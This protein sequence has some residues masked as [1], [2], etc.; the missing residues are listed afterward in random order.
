M[1]FLNLFRSSPEMGKKPPRSKSLECF[2]Y[3]AKVSEG[4]RFAR[5]WVILCYW[6][7]LVQLC[8]IIS[9]DVVDI[10]GSSLY[11]TINSIKELKCLICDMVASCSMGFRVLCPEKR[12]NNYTL[13]YGRDHQLTCAALIM[14]RRIWAESLRPSFALIVCL[15]TLASWEQVTSAYSRLEILSPVARDT[16]GPSEKS[17]IFMSVDRL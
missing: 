11:S 3:W 16:L 12:N 15:L 8:D 13:K 5:K 17:K 4:E 2:M 7:S 10:N 9:Q 1:A 6:C 14:S